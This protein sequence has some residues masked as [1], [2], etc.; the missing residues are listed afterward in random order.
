MISTA[1]G[2]EINNAFLNKAA[3]ITDMEWK[4]HNSVNVCNT[5]WLATPYTNGFE[6]IL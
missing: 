1:T 5:K 6:I 2:T 3:D 4:E